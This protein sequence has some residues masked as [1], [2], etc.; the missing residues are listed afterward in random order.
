MFS[1]DLP[2]DSSWKWET[3]EGQEVA[4]LKALLREAVGF[5]TRYRKET[6]L[7]HQPHMIAGKVDAFLAKTEVKALMEEKS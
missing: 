2:P 5:L 4:Q 6:P 7:G 3:T 1:A